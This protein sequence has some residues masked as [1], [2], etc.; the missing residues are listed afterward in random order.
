MK[1]GLI[2]IGIVVFGL[3]L[4]TFIVFPLE[5]HHSTL[6]NSGVSS[7]VAVLVLVWIVYSVSSWITEGFRHKNL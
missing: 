5:I 6:F 3:L 1:T 7:V 4:I 2:R